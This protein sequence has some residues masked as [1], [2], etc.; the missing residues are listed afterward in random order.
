[1]NGQEPPRSC[2]RDELSAHRYKKC[3][4]ASRQQYWK[5]A[6][7]MLSW[8]CQVGLQNHIVS[9]SYFT[10]FIGKVLMH[11]S[12]TT[13]IGT[14]LTQRRYF[15]QH[16]FLQGIFSRADQCSIKQLYSICTP[17]RNT[18]QTDMCHKITFLW[19]PST[20][21]QSASQQL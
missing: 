12:M 17:Q 19:D 20:K 13:L 2:R 3:I 8:H 21:A 4:H 18:K 9:S 1:M 7:A 11:S 6:D 15:Q 10:L 14:L 5:S 16:P